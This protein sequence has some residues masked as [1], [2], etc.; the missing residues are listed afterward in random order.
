MN[1][2]ELFESIFMSTLDLEKS[3]LQGLEYNTVQAWDSIGH[4]S[5]ISEIEE[6]F[7]IYLDVEDIISFS[8]FETGMEILK[9]YNV[10]F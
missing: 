1:N 2:K 10:E 8:S 3:Q 4:M 6:K 7:G 9:K 5:L